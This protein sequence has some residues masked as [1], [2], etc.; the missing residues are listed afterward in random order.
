MWPNT[1][2]T[3]DLVKFNKEILNVKLRFLCSVVARDNVATT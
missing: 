3:A 2:E 1:Q